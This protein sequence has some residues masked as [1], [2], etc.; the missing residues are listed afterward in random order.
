MCVPQAIMGGQIAGIVLVGSQRWTSAPVWQGWRWKCFSALNSAAKSCYRVPVHFHSL[1]QTL[2]LDITQFFY[3]V[4]ILRPNMTLTLL[5]TCIFFLILVPETPGNAVLWMHPRRAW[6]VSIIFHC[7]RKALEDPIG[8]PGEY[9][10]RESPSCEAHVLFD[11]CLG[12]CL[13]II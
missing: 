10:H 7:C 6:C 1:Y 9:G 3:F 11:K 5:Y 4:A 13:N 2:P 12:K 8:V